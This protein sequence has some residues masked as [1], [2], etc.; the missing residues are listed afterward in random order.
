MPAR[1]TVSPPRSTESPRRLWPVLGV[2]TAATLWTVTVE[3]LPSG[4][5]PQMSVG[6]GVSESTIGVL[7]SAWAVTIAVVGIP[8]VR[9]TLRVPRTA[10]LTGCLV[11][12]AAANLLTALAPGFALAL[13]GRI[14]AA[15]AHGLFWALVVSYVA[16]LVAPERLG[17]ALAVVLSGPTLAGLA[18]LPLAA[19][20][21]DLTDWRAVFAGLSIILLLT[22]AATW[23]VLPRAAAAAPEAGGVWTRGA[24]GVLAM[25]V[26]GGLVLVGHFTAFTYITTLTTGLGGL[27]GDA[28]P[29][30]LLVFG[31]AGAVGVVVSGFAADRYPRAAIGAAALLVCAGLL[32]LLLG[33][34]RP[35]VFTTGTAL[36][37]LAIGAFPPILQA[38]VLR[39]STP[40]FRPLAGS[41]VV[42]ILNLGVAAGA[43]LGGLILGHGQSTLTLAAVSAAAAGTLLLIL[44]RPAPP[45]TS[46]T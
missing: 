3:M 36:W 37:G 27:A 44:L 39:L 23:L 33:D 13:V 40:A 43:T 31:L 4:L 46:D 41:I 18:G 21:A 2:L 11:V 6:L 19:F 10:L 26:A 5:L 24:L 7:V 45:A 32:L 25:A 34:G 42:T 29:G 8:L 16:S 28:I 22:A 20:L 12:V 17:R 15:T 9:A 14:V 35:A 38:R 1:S 30:L